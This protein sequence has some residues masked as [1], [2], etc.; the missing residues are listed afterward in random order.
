MDHDYNPVPVDFIRS[1]VE[2]FI[3]SRRSELSYK[4]ICRRALQKRKLGSLE[5]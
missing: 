1:V 3:A 2:V 4:G 5:E